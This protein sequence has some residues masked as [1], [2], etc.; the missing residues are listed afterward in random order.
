VLLKDGDN[1]GNRHPPELWVRPGYHGYRRAFG[2]FLAKHHGLPSEAIDARWQVDHL[3]SRA[4]FKHGAGDYYVRLVLLDRRV[5]ASYGGG[6][7]KLLY[8]HEAERPLHGGQHLGYPGFLKV[9]GVR[10]PGRGTPKEE[11]AAWTERTVRRLARL[12]VSHVEAAYDVLGTALNLAYD[13]SWR[14]LPPTEGIL[15]HVAERERAWHEA[16]KRWVVLAQRMEVP[17]PL[18][19]YSTDDRALEAVQR[20]VPGLRWKHRGTGEWSA[21]DESV[22]PNV[23]YRILPIRTDSDDLYQLCHGALNLLDGRDVDPA[24]FA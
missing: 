16:D 2:R 20:R 22:E 21:W 3:C 1:N 18:G 19:I 5:N 4:R 14:P 10:I 8:A 13:R 17:V 15:R 6:Y 11:L 7:E 23:E 9:R 12:D 24:L